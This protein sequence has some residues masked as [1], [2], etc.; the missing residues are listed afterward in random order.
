V[1]TD[2]IESTP[3]Q[4]AMVAGFGALTLTVSVRAALET[5]GDP[6]Q[7]AACLAAAVV[8]WAFADLGTAIYHFFCDNY[9]NRETPLFGFQIA[10]FQG[11]HT[12]PWTIANRNFANN[13]YR[14]TIPTAPQMAALLVLPLSPMALAGLCSAL[15]WIVMSQE[16]H[17]QAHFTQPAA[18]ARVLQDLGIAIS[19]KEHGLHHS[20]PFDGHYGIVSG[21]SNRFLDES[22]FFRRLEALIYRRNGVEPNSWKLDPDVKE[23]ALKL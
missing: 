12:S 13:L 10:S 17:R 23:L 6:Q 9:G 4:T 15:G 7:A 8:G 3:L 22:L 20:S 11:H 5:H 19:K 2:S 14:L 16:L 1:D 21:I 18:Y